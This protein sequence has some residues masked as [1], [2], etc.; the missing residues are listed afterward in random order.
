MSTS[1]DI[2]GINV[3]INIS[4]PASVPA[5]M[6]G[7]ELVGFGLSGDVYSLDDKTVIKCEN[8]LDAASKECI[9]VERKVFQRLLSNPHPNIVRCIE[10]SPDGIVMERLDCTLKHAL[11]EGIDSIPLLQR[12]QWATEIVCGIHH[13]HQLGVLHGDISSH[14]VLLDKDKHAKVIDFAGSCVDGEQ[15]VALYSARNCSPRYSD[16]IGITVET[17]VFAVGSVL[18]EVATGSPPYADLTDDEVEDCYNANKFPHVV[19]LDMGSII[20]KCWAGLYPDMHTIALDL[21]QL[22]K[23]LAS[24]PGNAETL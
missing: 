3:C 15:S 22:Q 19:D 23:T 13:L 11:S 6:D 14:N 7:A 9:L 18:Y 1:A 20:E 5:I 12:I 21:A 4:T 17:E 16:P 8:D 24:N 10:L 2:E